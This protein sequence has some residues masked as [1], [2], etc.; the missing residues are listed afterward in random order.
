[1]RHWKREEEEEEKEEKEE[2]EK[3]EGAA[4][5]FRAKLR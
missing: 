4:N 1:V 3:E 2:K 5:C